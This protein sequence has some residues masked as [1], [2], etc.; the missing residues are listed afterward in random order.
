[1]E[2]LARPYVT[3][4]ERVIAMFTFLLAAAAFLRDWIL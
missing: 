4:Y 2:R 1:M 3:R